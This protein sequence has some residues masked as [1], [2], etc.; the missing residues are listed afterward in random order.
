MPRL[1]RVW[2]GSR[3]GDRI[4][5]LDGVAL[6]DSREAVIQHLGEPGLAE[7]GAELLFRSGECNA[8]FDARGK[9]TSLQFG[10][11]LRQLGRLLLSVGDPE[12][13]VQAVMGRASR[14]GPS[15]LGH[16][17]YF[18]KYHFRVYSREPT[19]IECLDLACLAQEP[20]RTTLQPTIRGMVLGPYD[21]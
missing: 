18:E 2:S 19:L 6:G 3:R 5:T 9:L 20:L 10:Q 8:Y 11:H 21:Y 13:R 4:S 12:D 17:L 1:C 14:T 16:A 7:G 15:P